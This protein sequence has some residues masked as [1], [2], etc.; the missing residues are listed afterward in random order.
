MKRFLPY[1]AALVVVVM[2]ASAYAFA[3]YTFVVYTPRALILTRYV[4]ASA[5]LLAV[6]FALSRGKPR[7]PDKRDMPLFAISGFF[8]IF[9][10]TW[11]LHEGLERVYAG[12][13]SFIMAFN[14]AVAMLLSVVVLKETLPR[15]SY[16]GLGL[17]L[18]G[19]VLVTLLQ[20]EGFEVNPGVF[21]LLVSAVMVGIYHILQRRILQKY[22]PI[23]ASSYCVLLGMLPMLAFLPQTIQAISIADTRTNLIV[24]YLGT[25]P[26]ALGFL[27][28]GYALSKAA[29]TTHITNLLFLMPF[30]SSLTG[31]A[32]GETI[33]LLELLGGILIV[34]GMAIS[35]YYSVRVKPT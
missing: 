16:Y 6:N 32:L 9:L 2:W 27:L 14:P 20:A 34:L 10:H 15:K 24:I 8:G 33:T 28:W 1:I 13:S 12:V 17:S 18:L 21:M 31:L 22:K 23:E 29:N 19:L 5:T 11:L 4:I 30:I 35:R 7:L 3:R 25:L 26:T